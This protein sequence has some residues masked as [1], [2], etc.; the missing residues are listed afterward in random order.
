[1]YVVNGAVAAA[2]MK[3]CKMVIG[4]IVVVKRVATGFVSQRAVW[5][6]ALGVSY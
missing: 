5:P 3:M 2:I 4:L 1:M 6:S